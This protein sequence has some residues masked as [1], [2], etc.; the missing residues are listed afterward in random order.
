[1]NGEALRLLPRNGGGCHRSRPDCRHDGVEQGLAGGV[2]A[3]DIAG[4]QPETRDLD[5]GSHLNR[6]VV[7][8]AVSLHP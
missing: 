8:V 7:P 6:E 2:P 5:A 4:S 1:V 3:S